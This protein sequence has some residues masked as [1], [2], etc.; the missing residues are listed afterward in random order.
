MAQFAYELRLDKPDPLAGLSVAEVELRG[1]VTGAS[2]V[3]VLNWLKGFAFVA[4]E[5]YARIKRAGQP[6]AEH[7]FTIPLK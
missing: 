4:G 2:D 6:A 5:Y 3:H 7:R 1:T